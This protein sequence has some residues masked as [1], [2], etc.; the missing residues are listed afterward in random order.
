MADS[1][2]TPDTRRSVI[3]DPFNH[4]FKRL[5]YYEPFIRSIIHNLE[6]AGFTVDYYK[7]NNVTIDLSKRLDNE[8]YEVIYINTHGFMDSEGQVLIFTGEKHTSEKEKLYQEDIEEERIRCFESKGELTGYYYVTPGFFTWYG[9]DTGYCNALIFIDA[10]HSANNTSM[11]KAFLDLDAGCYV[12]WTAYIGIEYD[13]AMDGK[14]FRQMCRDGE[15]V[16]QSIRKIKP[17]PNSK[18]KM[19]YFG[20]RSLTCH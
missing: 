18:S 4:Q 16:E 11:A 20:D 19:T 14:F 17:D 12:G 2:R 9:N 7:D 1:E 5:P 13:V 6:R 3:L 15:T 10:C 8:E